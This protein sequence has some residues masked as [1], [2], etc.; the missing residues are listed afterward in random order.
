MPKKKDEKNNLFYRIMAIFWI[1]MLIMWL[2]IWNDPFTL[3]LMIVFVPIGIIW[4]VLV[5][6]EMRKNN[7]ELKKEKNKTIIKE[8]ILEETNHSVEKWFN[9]DT[10]WWVAVFVII[11]WII[12]LF[13]DSSISRD[14]VFSW[15][16]WILI[17]IRYIIKRPL[18]II[19]CL[20]GLYWIIK[21]IKRA[22]EH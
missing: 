2:L 5:I 18:I 12:G 4:L 21:F 20:A 11:S 3:F 15:I 13:Q 7:K 9:W 10:F 16:F 8:T 6:K 14:D 19:W 22:R 1:P 17:V